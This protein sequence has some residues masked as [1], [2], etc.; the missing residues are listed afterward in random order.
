[1]SAYL[2]SQAR[3]GQVALGDDPKSQSETSL[4]VWRTVISQG[5]VCDADTSGDGKSQ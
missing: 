2:A 3:S 5:E 4:S 1:M